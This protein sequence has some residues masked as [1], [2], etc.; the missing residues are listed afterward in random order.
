MSVREN[1]RFAIYIK[2]KEINA[3]LRRQANKSEY[4]ERAI[5][6]YLNNHDALSKLAK[7]LTR[8]DIIVTKKEC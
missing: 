5:R 1:A 8:E 6:F 2:D 4:V 7:L 3:E